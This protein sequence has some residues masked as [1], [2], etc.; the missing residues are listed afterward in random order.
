VY[1]AAGCHLC[2]RALEQV[3]A[4]REELGFELREVD[5]EGDP[6]LEAGYREWLPVVEI[7]GRRRFTYHVQPDAFRRA[8]A[9]AT[10]DA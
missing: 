4:L 9:Q 10:P 1:H 2:E 7:D 8:V 6:V 5:I 3:R